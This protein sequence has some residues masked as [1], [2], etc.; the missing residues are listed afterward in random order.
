MECVAAIIHEVAR[1]DEVQV[2]ADRPLLQGA[3]PSSRQIRV[4]TSGWF[5]EVL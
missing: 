5:R 4:P 3:Q 1:Y 2:E